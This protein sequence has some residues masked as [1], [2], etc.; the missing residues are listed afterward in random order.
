[1]Q[2]SCS[3]TLVAAAIALNAAMKYDPMA[4]GDTAVLAESGEL[5]TDEFVRETL[6][7]TGTLIAVAAATLVLQSALVL[8]SKCSA[9][10]YEPAPGTLVHLK[11]AVRF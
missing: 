9:Y 10:V 3:L 6:A 11:L 4:E 7:V 5:E 2:A 8:A 1:M